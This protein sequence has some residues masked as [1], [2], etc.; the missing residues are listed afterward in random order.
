MASSRNSSSVI[1]PARN[2]ATN[3]WS[4]RLLGFTMSVPLRQEVKAQ[5]L[6]RRFNEGRYWQRTLDNEFILVRLENTEVQLPPPPQRT[7]QTHPVGT[8]HQM[9]EYRDP[10]TNA[11]IALVS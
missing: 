8:R 4:S 1:V 7:W 2:R 10:K 6:Q 9:W 5:E 11:K 3:A